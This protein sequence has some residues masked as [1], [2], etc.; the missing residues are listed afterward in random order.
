MNQSPQ[1]FLKRVWKFKINLENISIYFFFK[2][3][4]SSWK[5]KSGAIIKSA[6]ENTT[7]VIQQFKPGISIKE[8]IKWV[9]EQDSGDVAFIFENE[10]S[11]TFQEGKFTELED[12]E[13]DE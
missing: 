9:S 11:I 3:L 8:A 1:K 6:T 12:L 13:D 4:V 7:S 10:S 2:L 5:V